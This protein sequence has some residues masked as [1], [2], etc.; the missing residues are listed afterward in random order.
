MST[1]LF[2]DI[3]STSCLQKYIY[4]TTIHQVWKKRLEEE[5]ESFPFEASVVK[6]SNAEWTDAANGKLWRPNSSL[7]SS[8]NI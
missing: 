6:S 5:N 3:F 2:Q 7:P 1:S 4:K 8:C